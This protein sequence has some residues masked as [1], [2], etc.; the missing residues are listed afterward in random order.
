MIENQIPT[1]VC[2]KCRIEKPITQFHKHSRSK[3]GVL[4]ECK[5]CWKIRTDKWAKANPDKIKANTARQRAKN[6]ERI[7]E[8]QRKYYYA[9]PPETRSMIK[10][11]KRI[12]YQYGITTAEYNEILTSQGGVCAIC[13]GAPDKERWKKLAIDHNHSTGI[14]R[15]LL[16][17]KCNKGIGSLRDN[18]ELLFKAIEYLKAA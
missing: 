15:G 4:G 16:C 6:A 5:I 7:R 17:S 9:V 10:R 8:N 1:K 12:V 13:G 3:Y 2:N 11:A 14:V 18:V